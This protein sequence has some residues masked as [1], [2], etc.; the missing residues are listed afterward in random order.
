MTVWYGGD[1]FFG[2]NRCAG[3]RSPAYAASKLTVSL[4]QCSRAVVH[5]FDPRVQR[6]PVVRVEAAVDLEQLV[7]NR[8]DTLRIASESALT[9]RRRLGGRPARFH[10]AYAKRRTPAPGAVRVLF[11]VAIVGLVPASAENVAQCCA[12]DRV[13]APFLDIPRHVERAPGPQ[14]LAFPCFQRSVA[15]EVAQ[16]KDLGGG[17]LAR[18]RAIPVIDRREPLACKCGVSVRFEPADP[19]DREFVLASGKRT[20]LPGRRARSSGG[21]PE[22]AHRFTRSSTRDRRRGRVPSST[23]GSR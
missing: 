1:A 22:S 23:C 12:F 10:Q 3:T 9:G 13:R 15:V 5:A 6:R 8:H 21:V 17:L 18:R 11:Y 7:G 19:A 2:R 14:P 16:L 20:E 4:R